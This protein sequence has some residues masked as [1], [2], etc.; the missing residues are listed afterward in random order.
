MSLTLEDRVLFRELGQRSPA[1]HAAHTRRIYGDKRLVDNLDIV[2]ELGGHHGCVNALSWSRSG[3]FLASGSDDRQINIHTYLP[4]QTV[5][6]FELSTSIETG[7]TQN[8]FSVK[9]MPYSSD[10]IIVSCAGDCQV[11]VFD[12]EYSSKSSAANGSPNIGSLGRSEGRSS[13]SIERSGLRQRGESNTD[14]RVYRSH[15]NRVK[16]IVTESSPFHFLTCSED[17]EVRQWDLRQPSSAYPSQRSRSQR[18]RSSNPENSP[19]PLISYKRFNLDLNTISCSTSQPHYIA[20]GGAHLHC[21]LHDRRMIGR[22]M[23]FER[24]RPS[25]SHSASANSNAENRLMST[26]TRCV[27]KFAPQ[28]TA[29]MKQG[30]TGH[31]TACKISDRYPNELVAS[32]SGDWIYSFD[33]VQ[34]PDADELPR[35]HD[36]IDTEP[37]S[38]GNRKGSFRDLKRKRSQGISG[39]PST[40]QTS[41]DHDSLVASVGCEDGREIEIILDNPSTINHP[42]AMDL[43]QLSETEKLSFRIAEGVV[44]LRGDLFAHW[45]LDNAPESNGSSWALTSIVG[46]AAALL[47][48]ITTVLRLWRYPVDPTEEEVELHRL[49]RQRRESLRRFVQATGTMARVMGGQLRNNPSLTNETSHVF[50]DQIASFPNAH[51]LPL[52]TLF[53]YEFLRAILLW[54]G[55]GLEGLKKAFVKPYQSS[56]EDRRLPLTGDENLQTVHDHII[57]Y[58]LSLTS[59]RAIINVNAS[60]FETNETRRLF[61]TEEAAVTAFGHAI[62]HF[63]DDARLTGVED[64]PITP[65]QRPPNPQSR[66]AALKFW[67]LTVARGLLL[68]AS[69]GLTFAAVDTAFGGS[70]ATAV[71]DDHTQ[72]DVVPGDTAE[73]EFVENVRILRRGHSP[74]NM[75]ESKSDHGAHM[76]ESE[77]ESVD[78]SEESS[79]DGE[80]DGDDHDYSHLLFPPRTNRSVR[81]K[82]GAKV[83][84]SSHTRSYTGHANIRT[85]KDVGF[86]GL[87]DEYVVS[88]SDDGNLFIWDRKTTELVNI[89]QGDDEVVNVVQGHPHEPMLAVSGIDHTIKIFSADY[90]AQ[91]E[92]QDG[93][94]VTKSKSSGYSSLDRYRRPSPNQIRNSLEERSRASENKLTSKRRMEEEYAIRARNDGDRQQERRAIR[95]TVGDIPLTVVDFLQWLEMFEN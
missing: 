72:D 71:E 29:L 52:K 17:G 45:T 87:H 49:L 31:I 8:I 37:M 6:P 16:R 36:Q 91:A 86:Y 19:A 33:I 18:E 30:D 66:S 54:V 68:N 34:S 76:E 46:F 13:I 60:R 44:K 47:P 95:F 58:L 27:K 39:T 35:A 73:D 75:E 90:R 69:E 11:R 7:H 20:L 77:N 10:R 55:E 15:S 88:G 74:S 23:S 94:G 5:Q 14:C 63:T 22:D 80:D 2:N 59:N 56:Q 26:A 43:D 42:A 85:V 89:L 51:L 78:E 65:I 9:F 40:N 67:G 4:D 3:K 41:P 70:G 84:C 1:S 64:F 92:A 53:C 48:D 28:G 81:A 25:S 50:F 83:S 93:I 21:F 79:D 61:E 57:P 82:A 24:G 62:Q 38:R 32:W 12:I